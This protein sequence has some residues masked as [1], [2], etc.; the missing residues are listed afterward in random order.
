MNIQRT[1]SQNPDFIALVK[2]LD[3]YLK[4]VDGDEHE[5]YDQY[6]S[7]ENLHQVVV[8]YENKEP[9]ACGAIKEYDEV[10]VE[11][12]RMFTAT[13]YRGNGFATTVL[14]ELEKWASELGYTSCALE[15]GSKQI[16]AIALYKKCGYSI[17][18]NY[19]HYQNIENS[20]CFIKNLT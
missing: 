17:T 18:P 20:I 12:K 8:L 16:E 3:A 1:T 6:N 10:S 9:V 13:E 5:F 14:S 15:T 11:V 4:V 19:G 7:I 2:S